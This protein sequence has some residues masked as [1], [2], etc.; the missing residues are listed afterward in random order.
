M[1]IANANSMG[2]PLPGRRGDQPRLRVSPGSLVHGW[3]NFAV[4]G[5]IS[6]KKRN[7]TTGL[8]AKTVHPRTTSFLWHGPLGFDRC[9]SSLARCTWM[10][11]RSPGEPRPH[12]AQKSYSQALKKSGQ[13]FR[14]RASHGSHQTSRFLAR[15]LRAGC[16]TTPTIKHNHIAGSIAAVASTPRNS[17]PTAIAVTPDSRKKQKRP[18]PSALREDPQKQTP[19]PYP[20]CGTLCFL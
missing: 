17:T 10:E 14:G 5:W 16:P 15:F 4:G 11:P 9:P 1:C 3:Q 8:I 6:P 7:P 2:T 12:L 13:R 20:F 18:R 19:S